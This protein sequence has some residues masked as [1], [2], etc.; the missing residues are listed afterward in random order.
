MT[1]LVNYVYIF[2][3]HFPLASKAPTDASLLLEAAMVVVP[4]FS[5]A[6]GSY[7][8]TAI[9]SG[10]SRFSEVLTAT[11]Y[12]LVPYIALTPVLGLMSNVLGFSEQGSYQFIKFLTLFWVVLLLLMALKRLNDYSLSKA[13]GVAL[14]SVIAVIIMWAVCLLMFSLTVQ[15]IFFFTGF[16]GEINLK[17]FL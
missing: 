2:L 7:L 4:M 11:S 15:L 5:W 10:E 16:G 13:I 17:F 14:L 1:F 8:V 12:A 6:L 9:M 3:V